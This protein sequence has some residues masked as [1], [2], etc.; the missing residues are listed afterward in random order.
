[1]VRVANP[2]FYQIFQAS[3]EETIGLSLFELGN[4]QWD[5][6]ALRRLLEDVVRQD[7]V[8][9]DFDVMHDFPDIGRRV[10]VVN[11]R[12]IKMPDDA[13]VLLAIEDATERHRSR[14]V[15]AERALDGL[16]LRLPEE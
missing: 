9:E 10:M 16:D 11:A 6:P 3:P 15:L 8:V 7:T 1:M 4:G 2:A 14:Q 13:A 5:T 12:Q